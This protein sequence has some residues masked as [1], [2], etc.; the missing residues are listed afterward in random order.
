MAADSLQ[1]STQAACTAK[2]NVVDK[3][4][5]KQKQK[6]FFRHLQNCIFTHTQLSKERD[7]MMMMMM[8][9]M[10]MITMTLKMM[11]LMIKEIK[12]KA[13]KEDE[14]ETV[15]TLLFTRTYLSG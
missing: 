5:L 3:L 12:V 4:Y 14:A 1:S 9:M 7:M 2:K 13:T 15:M 10:M 8:T 6:Q 11:T